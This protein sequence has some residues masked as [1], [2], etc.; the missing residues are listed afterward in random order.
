MNI[1]RYTQKDEEAIVDLWN[2]TCTVDAIDV[3]K[4]RRQAIFDENFGV[5]AELRKWMAN[6]SGL[7][8]G[9]RGNF[10]ISRGGSSRNAAG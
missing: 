6:S 2:R 10:P 1:R 5:S 9:R 7:F 4:F 3:K 8:T